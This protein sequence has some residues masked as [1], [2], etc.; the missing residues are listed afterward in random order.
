MG[1]MPHP[2]RFID[3]THHPRWTRGGVRRADGRIFFERA[4]AHL[5]GG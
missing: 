4:F 3:L 2:E 1:L 5:A